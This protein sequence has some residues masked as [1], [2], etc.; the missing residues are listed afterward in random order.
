M[1]RGALSSETPHLDDGAKGDVADLPVK[2]LQDRG[3]QPAALTF[4]RET[5]SDPTPTSTTVGSSV[6]PA[7]RSSAPKTDI[8]DQLRVAS[9]RQ[10]LVGGMCKRRPVARGEFI[11]HVLVAVSPAEHGLDVRLAGMVE[12]NPVRRRIRPTDPTHIPS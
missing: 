7:T 11:G 6:I 12:M 9:D 10:I 3:H 8:A 4:T 5:W 1:L 2:R